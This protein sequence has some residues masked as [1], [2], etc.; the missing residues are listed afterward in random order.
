MRTKPFKLWT[1][2]LASEFGMKKLVG[3]DAS[4]IMGTAKE[5][6]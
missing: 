1:A 5:S 4:A 3:V 2:P 6:R